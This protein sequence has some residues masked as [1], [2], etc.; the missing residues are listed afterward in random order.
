MPR[1]PLIRL[2]VLLARLIHHLYREGR[3][4]TVLV[5]AGGLQ[6]VAHEL[7]VERRWIA[8]GAVLVG[9]PEARAVW[10]QHLVYQD[11]LAAGGGAPLELGV[12]DD[13]AARPSVIGGPAI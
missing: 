5:P 4:G 10:S 6:P 11:Q 1:Q 7:L 12:G 3:R 8:A 2:Q 13:D 9:R